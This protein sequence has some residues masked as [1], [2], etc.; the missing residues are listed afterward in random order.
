MNLPQIY[1]LSVRRDKV[2]GGRVDSIIS[3]ELHGFAEPGAYIGQEFSNLLAAI[4]QLGSRVV[5]IPKA[6]LVSHDSIGRVELKVAGKF[7]YDDA[8]K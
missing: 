6:I 4:P 3:A 5:A 2:F 7:P 8:I 1:R